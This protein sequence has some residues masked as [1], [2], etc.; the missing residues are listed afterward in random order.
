MTKQSAIFFFDL[1]DCNKNILRGGCILKLDAHSS[2]PIL[3]QRYFGIFFTVILG[4]LGRTVGRPACKRKVKVQ[5]K[6]TVHQHYDYEL[7]LK[8]RPIAALR[9]D[10]H[11]KTCERKN[12][13][14][15]SKLFLQVRRKLCC[16]CQKNEFLRKTMYKKYWSKYNV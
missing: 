15:N 5:P 11:E 2:G 3:W 9:W 8:G 1:R 14:W 12:K 16:F 7:Y 10:A 4:S 13:N 6:I